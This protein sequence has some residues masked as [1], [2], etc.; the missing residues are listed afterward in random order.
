MDGIAQRLSRPFMAALVFVATLGCTPTSPIASAAPEAG[1]QAPIEDAWRGWNV[2]MTRGSE[3]VAEMELRRDAGGG[4]TVAAYGPR[5]IAA[6]AMQAA[7]LVASAA[8][9]PG[10]AN[11]RAE[12]VEAYRHRARIESE[13]TTALEALYAAEG[14]FFFC[15]DVPNRPPDPRIVR[16]RA[17]EER[18]DARL[19]VWSRELA[20]LRARYNAWLVTQGR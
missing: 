15:V 2:A 14:G 8:A 19:A 17:E 3:L 12:F 10:A 7:D 9:P 20:S 13:Y 1:R 11:Y 18:H 6:M 16:C 5:E 4:L